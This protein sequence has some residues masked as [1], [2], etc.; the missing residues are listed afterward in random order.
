MKGYDKEIIDTTK[1]LEEKIVNGRTVLE[2]N[3]LIA[4]LPVRE[5]RGRCLAYR[6]GDAT[7]T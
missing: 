7:L 2:Y 1:Y 4:T 5:E 3:S 6:I